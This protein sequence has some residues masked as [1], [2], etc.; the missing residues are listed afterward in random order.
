[1]RVVFVAIFSCP[2]CR[3]S[4]FRIYGRYLFSYFLFSF[5]NEGL[6]ALFVVELRHLFYFLVEE[7]W[8]MGEKIVRSKLFRRQT[9]E[10]MTVFL[11]CFFVCLFFVVVVVFFFKLGEKCYR[12]AARK[13]RKRFFNFI[14]WKFREQRYGELWP[15]ICYLQQNAESLEEKKRRTLLTWCQKTLQTLYQRST[16]RKTNLMW[17]P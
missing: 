15:A 6:Q 17:V 5:T 2:F 13:K 16:G 7:D 12:K 10:C 1:M 8:T 3:F 4:I 14:T 9:K 11:F